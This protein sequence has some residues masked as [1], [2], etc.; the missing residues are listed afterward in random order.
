MTVENMRER[1]LKEYPGAK[2]HTKV[3]RMKDEQVM[4]IYFR[5]VRNQ[6]TLRRK[7]P[8]QEKAPPSASADI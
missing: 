4:A 6:G 1:I 8:Q 2:W 5:M 7:P 3:L